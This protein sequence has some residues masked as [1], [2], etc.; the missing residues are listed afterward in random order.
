MSLYT[1]LCL[2]IFW[3]QTTRRIF[4]S[5]PKKFP[6][7]KGAVKKYDAQTFVKG[8]RDTFLKI[9]S[10]PENYRSEGGNSVHFWKALCPGFLKI[11]KSSP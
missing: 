6:I 8:C 3:T 5:E 1:F 7:Y 10:L 4:P 11:P 2:T 9:V